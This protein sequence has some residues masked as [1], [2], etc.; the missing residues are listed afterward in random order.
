MFSLLSAFK[1]EKSLSVAGCPCYRIN[2]GTFIDVAPNPLPD[3]HP[4]LPNYDSDFDA[5]CLALLRL[6]KTQEKRRLGQQISKRQGSRARLT[7]HRF[8]AAFFPPGPL[9]PND[10]WKHCGLSEFPRNKRQ[11]GHRWYLLGC[12]PARR[13]ES[14]H[15]EGSGTSVGFSG[16]DVRP[17]PPLGS[18]HKSASL[19]APRAWGSSQGF[20]A[21][22]PPDRRRRGGCGCHQPPLSLSRRGCDEPSQ[23]PGDP[24]SPSVSCGGRDTKTEGR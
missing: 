2:L 11:A 23:S 10:P 6:Y 8:L 7:E 9:Q 19:G 12:Q 22:L 5:G 20:P 14:L 17:K 4:F 24:G 16:A 15:A 1:Q 21:S 3:I 13:G 18:G